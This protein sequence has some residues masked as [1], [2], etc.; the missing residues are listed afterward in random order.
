MSN[1]S[2]ERDSADGPND[3]VDVM[4]QTVFVQFLSRIG[5]TMM[6]ADSEWIS[7]SISQNPLF[8]KCVQDFISEKERTLLVMQVSSR[9]DLDTE[10][11]SLLLAT[12]VQ[13]W[14]GSDG[15]SAV[16]FV[17]NRPFLSASQPLMTQLQIISLGSMPLVDILHSYIQRSFKPMLESCM[18]T[19]PAQPEILS[20]NQE[21]S[22]TAIVRKKLNELEQA[23]SSCRRSAS[24]PEVDL[25]GQVRDE[26]R[27]LVTRISAESGGAEREEAKD[28][29]L[30]IAKT[31][32]ALKSS[33][34]SSITTWNKE[35]HELRMRFDKQLATEATPDAEREFWLR[36]E[37]V[38][39]HADEQM[40]LPEVELTLE[41]VRKLKIRAYIPTQF[42]EYAAAIR[43]CLK[44]VHN[45][46]ILME[47]LPVG[48]IA[49]AP[50]IPSLGAAVSRFFDHMR[51]NLPRSRYPVQRAV[52]LLE[53][54]SRELADRLVA[55]LR[56]QKPMRLRFD[57]FFRL[58]GLP[59][60]RAAGPRRLAAASG[61]APPGGGPGS[62]Q[63]LFELWD[64]REREF[65]AD[66]AK[67]RKFQVD[68]LSTSVRLDLSI[69]KRFR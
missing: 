25:K 10:K 17:K 41:L 11:K 31:S 6:E 48:E 40:R 23:L 2:Q 60:P 69:E 37:K 27:N 28:Q 35:L 12:E 32:E 18:T 67:A 45:F 7:T 57:D 9:G 52:Q 14:T 66:T 15:D 44:N 4:D 29:L 34:C 22:G 51:K 54:L 63:E 36:M 30:S 19:A 13:N 55:L 50:D 8:T 61:D 68:S 62:C 3:H 59:D 53:A 5:S 20:R 56:R 42:D 16:A 65:M 33:L 26:V 21:L 39:L 58:C 1:M 43:D 46:K 47:K 38:L 64:A 24:I 49:A